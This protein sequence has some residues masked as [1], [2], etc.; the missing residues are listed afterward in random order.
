MTRST[1]ILRAVLSLLLLFVTASSLT[2]QVEGMDE[3]VAEVEVPGYTKKTLVVYYKDGEQ[4][5]FPFEAL[6]GMLR[7]KLERD[8]TRNVFTARLAEGK[9]V[10]IDVDNN[11]LISP[12]GTF[13]IDPE[14]LRLTES[15]LYIS[16]S[17]AAKC[18]SGTVAFD[19][20]RLYF[21]VEGT[22]DLPVVSYVSARTKWGELYVQLDSTSSNGL[23]YSLDRPLIGKASV[24]WTL[25]ASG[26]T[27]FKQSG[28]TLGTEGSA[29]IMMPF[30]FGN[31]TFGG[32]AAVGYGRT[33]LRQT[34]D[35]RY[36]MSGW[37]WS[38]PI[39]EFA[40]LSNILLTGRSLR[41]RLALSLSNGA[42]GIG[43]NVT[44]D[45][46]TGEA[47]PGNAVELYQNGRL[48]GI[49]TADSS[50]EFHF[51]VWKTN[52]YTQLT[53]VEID[54]FAERHTQTFSWG[55]NAIAT[56]PGSV[57]YGLRFQLDSVNVNAPFQGDLTLMV[58]VTRWLELGGR[59][60]A[61]VPSLRE[62]RL[63][64]DTSNA[65]KAVAV[66][67]TLALWNYASISGAYDY[68]LDRADASLSTTIATVPLTF[69]ASNIRP[70]TPAVRWTDGRYGVATG[71]SI[72]RVGA[73]ISSFYEKEFISIDPS[74]SGLIGDVGVSVSP[75]MTYYTG[76]MSAAPGE[77]TVQLP[78]ARFEF[79]TLRATLSSPFLFGGR[80]GVDFDYN[81]IFRRLTSVRME[82]AFSLGDWYLTVGCDI[83]NQDIEQTAVRV[84]AAFA[85]DFLA[86]TTSSTTTRSFF[87]ALNTL[88][89]RLSASSSG[90]EVVNRSSGPRIQLLAFNDLNGN[91]L[92]DE[93][94]EDLRNPMGS[95][96]AGT[97][98][99]QTTSSDSSGLFL[100]VP[101]YQDLTIAVDKWSLADLDIF[102]SQEYYGAYATEYT[103]KTIRVPFRRGYSVSGLCKIEKPGPNGTTI[104]TTNGLTSV[105]IWLK[106]VDGVGNYE[107]E[108]FEDGTALIIGVPI[109]EYRIVYDSSQLEYRRLAPKEPEMPITISETNQDLPLII[110]VPRAPRTENT[111]PPAESDGN[112]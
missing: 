111:V 80:I 110:L 79:N 101:T 38:F 18:F 66:N 78:D 12:R 95:M 2:A 7:C 1:N 86:F 98:D 41:D 77:D 50:G 92:Q 102:P 53:T 62:F 104:Q 27:S 34:T 10:Q 8:A 28:L 36:S 75:S 58:G 109:G 51:T 65:L 94:E 37:A 67:G 89:G 19:I 84:G 81:H 20:A 56:R 30:L 107:G 52:H 21:S 47:A 17:L 87:R 13:T 99:Q 15:D 9:Q 29:S 5:Y 93:G 55:N 64:D 16:D 72:G 59:A 100:P 60:T 74:L 70:R 91:G 4:P 105:R 3:G 48:I 6:M 71:F 23:D 76:P 32:G 26:S 57:T 88:R 25:G 85:T 106:A 22:S 24:S 40:P 68:F 35:T 112:N 82:T 103:D 39:P 31:L 11:T 96:T 61:M 45:T 42:Y 14:M 33:S 69:M 83:P 54:Q 43:R 46:L 108:L 73:S 49:T 44:V 97:G 63:K 90:I